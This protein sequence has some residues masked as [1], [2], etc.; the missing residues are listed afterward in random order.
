MARVRIDMHLRWRFVPGV[1]L[2]QLFSAWKNN[3]RWW[4]T[5][6][7]T[8]RKIASFRT[9]RAC[10]RCVRLLLNETDASAWKSA[11]AEDYK[12]R[13]DLFL[14]TVRAVERVGGSPEWETR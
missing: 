9:I 13:T 7:P 14:A 10:R 11:K 2:H 1:K 5:H 6:V 3:G 8:G 4:M 12:G